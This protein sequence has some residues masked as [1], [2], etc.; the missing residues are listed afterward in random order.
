MVGYDWK[1]LQDL[2]GRIWLGRHA[3]LVVGYDWKVMRD[4]L[5]E[6]TGKSSGAC[7]TQLLHSL[8][9][10]TYSTF[11]AFLFLATLATVFSATLL[12]ASLQAKKSISCNMSFQEAS[13]TIILC[14][15]SSTFDTLKLKL[16]RCPLRFSP[17]KIFWQS[18][19]TLIFRSFCHFSNNPQNVAGDMTLTLWRSP[20]TAIHLNSIL[21]TSQNVVPATKL[22]DAVL[23]YCAY[24]ADANATSTHVTK[25]HKISYLWDNRPRARHPDHTSWVPPNGEA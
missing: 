16:L 23:K 3:R 10:F 5:W 18:S 8:S 19:K 13:K 24:H 14:E 21:A 22:Q 17:K 1:V 15:T 7:K 11:V 4:R 20:A 12:S 9:Y 2:W 25:R 6:M